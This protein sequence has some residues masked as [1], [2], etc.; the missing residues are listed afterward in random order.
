MERRVAVFGPAYLDRVLRVDRPLVD[1]PGHPPLDQ[2][3][4]G[5]GRFAPGNRLEIV[6]PSGN[7]IEVALPDGWPGP[8]GQILL[9]QSLHSGAAGRR[10]VQGL[11]W[12]DDLGGMGAG[13]AA[14]LKGTLHSALGREDD[15]TSREI[16]DLWQGRG[17]TTNRSG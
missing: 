14:A 16:S 12:A 5:V 15:P 10:F 3:H 8:T 13:F 2:S 1:Q 11:S 9:A 4:E 17:S 7:A 6:D